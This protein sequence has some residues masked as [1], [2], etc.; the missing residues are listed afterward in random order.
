VSEQSPNTSPDFTQGKSMTLDE[1]VE[2][3]LANVE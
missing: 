1:G 2:Y 3:A